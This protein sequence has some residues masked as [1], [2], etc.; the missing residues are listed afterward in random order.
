MRRPDSVPEPA[1]VRSI[2]VAATGVIAYLVGHEIDTSWIEAVL[3]LYGWATPVLA[4]VLI[5]PVVTPV[6]AG[7]H[8]RPE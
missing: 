2:L 3:T 5:R 4:G 8:T 1:L 7:R 6:S